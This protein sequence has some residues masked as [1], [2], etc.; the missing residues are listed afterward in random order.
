MHAI[1]IDDSVT[2]RRIIAGLLGEIGFVVDEA[3]DGAQGLKLLER[4]ER[5]DLA[6]VDWNMPNVDGLEFVSQARAD[7]ANDGMRIVM[8]TTEHEKERV[9]LAIEA[10]A[11]EYIMKPFTRE[12]LLEKLALVGLRG[13]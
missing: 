11:D 13:R 12:V 2:T 10:G 8:V 5:L 3:E 6:V 9:M 7:T 1:V 4:F